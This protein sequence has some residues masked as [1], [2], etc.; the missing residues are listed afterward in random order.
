MGFD[1]WNSG[2][3][4]G[5]PELRLLQRQLCS[6]YATCE[7]RDYTI[8]VPTPYAPCAHPGKW[9]LGGSGAEGADSSV[10]VNGNLNCPTICE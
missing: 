8:Q 2:E 9:V 7:F 1:L 5:A 3:T 6:S 4:P 10:L